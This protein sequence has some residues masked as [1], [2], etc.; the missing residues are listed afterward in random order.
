MVASVFIQ[1]SGGWSTDDRKIRTW[2]EIR[3]RHINSRPRAVEGD[4]I[5]F[6]SGFWIFRG[7]SKENPR[8]SVST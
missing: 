4:G 1:P 5:N 6:C 2:I 7:K 3:A 8:T